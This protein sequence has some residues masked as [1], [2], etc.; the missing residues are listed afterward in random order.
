LA[1]GLPGFDKTDTNADNVGM[2]KILVVEDNASMREML[3]SIIAEKGFETENAAWKSS[4]V[5]SQ[6]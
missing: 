4:G 1:R 3:T 6:Q 2:A 5:A